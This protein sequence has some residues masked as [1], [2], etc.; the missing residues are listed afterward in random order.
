M[1]VKILPKV[2]LT[3]YPKWEIWNTLVRMVMKIPVP[4][5]RTSMGIPQ[6]KLLTIPLTFVI[7]S[8]IHAFLLW[9]LPL[10]ERF[11][12]NAA[13]RQRVSLTENCGIKNRRNPFLFHLPHCKCYPVHSCTLIK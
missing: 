10:A 6:T 13:A 4:T 11:G 8:I 5:K 9:I 1:S 2:C 7:I 12:I 3:Q